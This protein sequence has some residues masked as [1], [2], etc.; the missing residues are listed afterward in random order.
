MSIP[1][2]GGSGIAREDISRRNDNNDGLSTPPEK[3]SFIRQLTR[4][5]VSCMSSQL[6]LYSCSMHTPS[7]SHNPPVN[8]LPILFLPSAFMKN[9]RFYVAKIWS[10]I[11]HE[12][13]SRI[14]E[15]YF[16][17]VVLFCRQRMLIAKVDSVFRIVDDFT[18]C[19]L[20]V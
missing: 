3:F 18:V 11:P 1:H 14:V 9:V 8:V 7:A 19:T 2:F 16:K 20:V 10:R 15:G 6:Y 12:R 13:H 17:L 5:S 4:S